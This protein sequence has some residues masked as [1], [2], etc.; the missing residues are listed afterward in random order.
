MQEVR[1]AAV[2]LLERALK[3][4]TCLAPLVLPPV[5]AAL[6]KLPPGSTVGGRERAC[7][8]VGPHRGASARQLPT[9]PHAAPRHSS[10]LHPSPSLYHSPAVHASCLCV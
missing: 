10:V 2:G 6:A 5:L 4:Y 3:R 7:P 9:A 8:A 1:E